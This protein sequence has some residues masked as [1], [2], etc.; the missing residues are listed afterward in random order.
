MVVMSACETG[1]IEKNGR[2]VVS[3]LSRAFLYAGARRVVATLWNVDDR[4]T[5]E[6]MTRFYRAL[7]KDGLA[8]AE[9]LRQAQREMRKTEWA[10][11]PFWAGFVIQG[12]E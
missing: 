1:L 4:A 10:A 7:W 8:P 2:E 3:G 5:T 6:L 12:E 9:A 11:P